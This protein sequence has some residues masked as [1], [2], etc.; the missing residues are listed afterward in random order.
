MRQSEMIVWAGGEHAFRLGIG[1]L[2]AIEQRS[3]AG[4]AVVMMRLLSSAWK[5]DD[6][7]NPIRL[8]LIGG[9]LS[10]TDAQKLIDKVLDEQA[11]L[12]SL[13]VV[14]ADILKRFLMWEDGDDQPGEL[15]AG[16]TTVSPRSQTGKP[17]GPDTTDQAS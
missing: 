13:A 17:D 3:D 6:I 12:Y 10:A 14:A 1:E 9:G 8:G 5:V 16:Q 4:C 2:R 15:K 11:S 7:L